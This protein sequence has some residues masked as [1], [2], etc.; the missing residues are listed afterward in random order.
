MGLAIA[1][2]GTG[3][4]T[5]PSVCAFLVSILKDSTEWKDIFV[6]VIHCISFIFDTTSLATVTVITIDR[7]LA[8]NLHLRYQTYVT[9]K[10]T[11]KLLALIW[12]ASTVYSLT[13]WFCMYY[14][15][16]D[17]QVW[18]ILYNAL[19]LLS[20]LINISLM[21]KISY[22]V[23]KH[24][25]QIRVQHQQLNIKRYKKT[26]NTMY[27]I[28][29]A[30]TICFIPWW[31]YFTIYISKIEIIN[32]V[33]NKRTVFVWLFTTLMN[34][35]SVFNPLLYFWRIQGMRDAAKEVLKMKT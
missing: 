2:F 28:M 9:V 23:R 16:T 4:F 11:V 15:L 14:D 7:F 18:Y 30:F 32:N 22:A 12:L 17:K 5:Q 35:S 27:F 26:V 34:I 21:F 1:D 13:Y 33:E 20:I 3:V 25:H 6:E 29:G 10:K 31:V 24:S 19:V 8:I